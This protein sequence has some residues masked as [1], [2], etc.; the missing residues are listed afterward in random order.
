MLLT[1]R[2][3]WFLRWSA[4]LTLLPSGADSGSKTSSAPSR[5]LSTGTGLLT[6]MYAL[7][8]S[9]T[10]VG[11]LPHRVGG[12]QDERTLLL[13]IARNVRSVCCSRLIWLGSYL[14]TD[15]THR[16][17]SRPRMDAPFPRC[18]DS[19]HL[20]GSAS[21]QLAATLKSVPRYHVVTRPTRFIPSPFSQ[22]TLPSVVARC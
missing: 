2:V 11:R 20:L 17:V 22:R 15:G 16:K 3:Q 5:P 7:N 19:C 14:P 13:A 6:S 1:T 12:P 4:S 18:N 8:L 10:C 9:F 21:L